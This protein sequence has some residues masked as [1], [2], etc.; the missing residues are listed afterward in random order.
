MRL[1]VFTVAGVILPLTYSL[2]AQM[3]PSP[4]SPR[5]TTPTR[6][7]HQSPCWQQAGVSQSAIQKHRQIE[8]STRSQVESVCADSALTPQQKHEK[9]RQLHQEAQ[10]QVRSLISPQQE[11]TLKSCHER[12]GEGPHMGGVHG[13]GG[14]PCGEMTSVNKP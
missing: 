4:V 6:P 10:Q 2:A 9:I 3:A 8:E 1:L 11:Q 13:G 5:S 12:R 14:G 7:A